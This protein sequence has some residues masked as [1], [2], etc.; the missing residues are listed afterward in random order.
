MHKNLISNPNRNIIKEIQDSLFNIESIDD[1]INNY[2]KNIRKELESRSERQNEAE[3][4]KLNEISI[5]E[6]IKDVFKDGKR[7]YK[8]MIQKL[9]L[10]RISEEELLEVVFKLVKKNTD[11]DKFSQ[12]LINI[13]NS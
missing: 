2:K 6:Q 9:N 13:I 1:F 3:V 12:K 11:L 8:S 7:L 4:I 5:E 10:Y